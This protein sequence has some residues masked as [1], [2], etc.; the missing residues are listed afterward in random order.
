MKG[1][2]FVDWEPNVMSSA[3]TLRFEER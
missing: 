1:E 3:V 2:R